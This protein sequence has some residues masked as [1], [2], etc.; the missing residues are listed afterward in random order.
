MAV[1][2]VRAA[3]RA[4]LVYNDFLE[5]KLETMILSGYRRRKISP[6]SAASQ[7]LD[8]WHAI[9]AATLTSPSR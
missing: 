3:L 9:Q 6:E 1:S 8:D 4:A 2:Q 7:T 5:R